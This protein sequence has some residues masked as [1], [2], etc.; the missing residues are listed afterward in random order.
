MVGYAPEYFEGLGVGPPL[1]SDHLT[2]LDRLYAMTDAVPAF[3][4]TALGN[5]PTATPAEVADAVVGR[6]SDKVVLSQ[7]V[8]PKGQINSPILIGDSYLRVNNRDLRWTVD[9]VPG[10]D[11]VD[12]E[13]VLA[14][15]NLSGTRWEVSGEVTDNSDG[16]W[17]L[18]FEILSEDLLALRPGEY[19]WS[20]GVRD[21]TGT[22]ITSV[23][24]DCRK[25]VSLVTPAAWDQQ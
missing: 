16:T 3:T 15:R 11:V 9:A 10:V 18:S 13:C 24:A 17:Q 21:S 4:E 12:T 19:T 6:L 22:Q 2:A 25:P 20:A 7:S 23:L 5:V 1:T 8:S 14:F